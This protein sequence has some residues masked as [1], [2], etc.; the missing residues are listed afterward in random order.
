MRRLILATTLAAALAPLAALEASA[1]SAIVKQR[2]TTHALG[3]AV[4][5]A[6]FIDVRNTT[7]RTIPRGAQ[8]TLVIVVKGD[9]T[10]GLRKTVTAKQE[11]SPNLYHA[12]PMPSG[13]TSC[14]ASVKLLPDYIR[15]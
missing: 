5:T 11:L 6:G 4:T 14:S 2:H 12:F 15:R 7:K 10:F 3:C 1:A 9:R 8:I 13:T